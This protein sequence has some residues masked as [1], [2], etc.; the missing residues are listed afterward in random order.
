MS[1]VDNQENINPNDLS[2]LSSMTLSSLSG[3]EELIK[4]TNLSDES[5]Q[6]D[7]LQKLKALQVIEQMIS[8]QEQLLSGD[9]DA[10]HESKQNSSVPLSGRS[11][12][13]LPLDFS[14]SLREKTPYS[15]PSS[16]PT[17]DTTEGISVCA[18]GLHGDAVKGNKVEPQEEIASLALDSCGDR[19][20]IKEG[21]A[22]LSQHTGGRESGRG[23][24]SEQRS[25]VKTSR[26]AHNTD[27]LH[28]KEKKR[29]EQL[30]LLNEKIAQRHSKLPRKKDVA[31]KTTTHPST[32]SSAA[33]KKAISS[34]HKTVSSKG[35][36]ASGAKA[37]APAQEKSVAKKAKGSAKSA[38]KTS[39]SSK[40][41]PSLHTSRSAASPAIPSSWSHVTLSRD[42]PPNSLP[43]HT[44]P[45][46]KRQPVTS[47]K[48]SHR[49]H[50]L[51][52]QISEMKQMSFS[53]PSE[54][55]TM[56]ASFAPP[57][58][59]VASLLLME[60][61]TAATDVTDLLDS[62]S[63]LIPVDG[64]GEDTLLPDI[65]AMA[66]QD[67]LQHSLYSSDKMKEKENKMDMSYDVDSLASTLTQA[68]GF[69]TNTDFLFTLSSPQGVEPQG[70]EPRREEDGVKT[71]GIKEM[72]QFAESAEMMRSGS[73]PLKVKASSFSPAPPPS[74]TTDPA[75]AANRAATVIQAAW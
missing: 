62:T 67:I 1:Y 60:D 25:K 12:D 14:H 32:S 35:R 71:C 21:V 48:A 74:C 45:K 10:K 20:T 18:P 65:S 46:A 29:E 16:L 57:P 15:L 50:S 8:T 75:M 68:Y 51:Q 58:D 13:A 42:P 61:G 69:S 19:S 73:I 9:Q 3:L 54:G 4:G 52:P 28:V 24:S 63:Y 22:D 43:S 17:V 27:K 2:T 38:S 11:S 44:P 66:D 55:T 59:S 5:N 6:T 7:L 40:S 34:T 49:L 72:D 36:V 41:A 26:P 30:R 56:S 33:G 39:L 31:T 70:V 47:P 23:P 64:D 37:R 53:S